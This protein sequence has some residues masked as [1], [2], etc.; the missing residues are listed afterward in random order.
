M[1]N[2]DYQL[3]LPV[4][5]SGEDL[6]IPVSDN[7]PREE[8]AKD[9]KYTDWHNIASQRHIRDLA[10]DLNR[11]DLWLA[12][13]GGVLHWFP[14]KDRFTRYASEHG[15]PG[16]SVYAIA[17]DGSGQVWVSSQQ[18]GLYYLKNDIW[19]SYRYLEEVQVSCLTT[20]S[21]SKLWVG[22][23]SGIYA[24]ANPESKPV[25]ELPPPGF[26]PRAMAI[27]NDNDIWL[28]NATGV[29]H[30][31]NSAWI[32]TANG[33]QPD[34]LTLA[35]QG[36]NLWLGK[37]RELVRI[38]LT[39]NTSPKI[40]NMPYGEVT[41]I[42][43]CSQGV[44]VA[45]GG[46]VGIVTENSWKPLKNRR[47]NTPITSLVAVSDEEVW[48]G[49]HD[50]LW[51]GG[52]DNIRR[53]LTDTP[54]DVIGSSPERFFSNLVQT[55]SVQQIAD[56][57]VLWIGTARGLFRYNLSIDDWRRD[58][59][60]DTQ[61]IRAIFNIPE[62]ETIW[63]ASWSKGLQGLEP[64]KQ[65]P[66]ASKISEPILAFTGGRDNYWAVGIDGL[67]RYDDS[68][69][70]LAIANSDLPVRG[71]VQSVSLVVS[72]RV[73]LGTTAG[74]F[75]YTPDSKQLTPVTG[76]LGSADVSVLLAIARNDS[77]L[78]FA[79]T[80]QGLYAGNLDKWETVP[81]LEN[82][83]IT[84]LVWDFHDNSLWVGTDRGL[85]RLQYRDNTWQVVNEFNVRNSGL[86]ENRVIAIAIS[87]DDSGETQLWVGTACGL[88]CYRY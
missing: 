80:K 52:K 79:G 70:K 37:F 42:A 66:T 47:F 76:S 77:E 19:E 40:D 51:Q 41:A 88:S 8:F 11:G 1:S 75:L 21:T 44:W 36:N 82:R 30:Y 59:R 3:D 72:D 18:L 69:W 5:V 24:I 17:V 65:L 2:P 33:T 32:A 6:P 78:L 53:H 56:R 84:A 61:D 83:Q 54:P 4:P 86:G 49:T 38:D 50:G 10:L 81:E 26:P 46:Q 27:N 73:W 43:P 39:T 25:L 45:C 64:G 87:R 31:Q 62:Q 28:C 15:L 67:Y 68:T 16:N 58:G 14:G 74:L 48:I 71:W 13:G 63:V 85:F 20:D 60:F 29:H 7:A 23:D 57:S 35:L 22:T 12:T 34:I 55:L 9:K